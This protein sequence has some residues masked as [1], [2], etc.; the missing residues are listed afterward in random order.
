MLGEDFRTTR[1]QTFNFPLPGAADD[2]ATA[3]VRFV[4]KTTN[5]ASSLMFKA[6]G[7]AL[8]A[9]AADRIN[10]SSSSDYAM[11]VVTAKQIEGLDGSLAFTI[12]YSPSGTLFTACLDYIAP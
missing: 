9:T 4:A 7:E 8:E 2:K 11:A 3:N 10:G 6:N 5:G 1:S 12:D